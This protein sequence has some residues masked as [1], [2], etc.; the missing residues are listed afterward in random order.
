[1]NDGKALALVNMG[2]ALVNMALELVNM[3]LALVNMVLALVNMALELVKNEL[4]VHLALI[5]LLVGR[6]SLVGYMLL[7]YK[8]WSE[9]AQ[10]S[11]RVVDL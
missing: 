6:L 7:E 11:E 8:L 9:S 4:Q 2:Q 3:K 1:M 10:P 5:S